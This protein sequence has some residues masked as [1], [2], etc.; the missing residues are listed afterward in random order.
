MLTIL[1]F[2]HSGQIQTDW[3]QVKFFYPLNLAMEVG[4]VT[5]KDNAIDLFQ[6]SHFRSD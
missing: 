3:E 6:N 2:H 1:L 4:F 5:I